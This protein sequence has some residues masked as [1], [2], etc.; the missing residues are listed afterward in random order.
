MQIQDSY[1]EST[2]S[3]PKM[4]C[5]SEERLISMALSDVPDVQTLRFDLSQRQLKA[6]HKGQLGALL[7][8]CSPWVSEPRS[9]AH[10]TW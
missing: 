5:P 9:L 4:D 7:G 2:F 8:A 6:V 3:V 10:K 1:Q